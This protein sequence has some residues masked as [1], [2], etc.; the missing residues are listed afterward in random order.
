MRLG[1]GVR[2]L[3]FFQLTCLGWALFRAPSLEACAQVWRKLLLFEGL[4]LWAW[5]GHLAARNEVGPVALWAAVFVSAWLIQNLVP[6]SS[7]ELVARLWRWPS[8]PRAL[9]LAS[10]LY[11]AMLLAPL[12]PPEFIYFQF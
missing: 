9:V 5:L 12:D 1:R 8:V 7:K 6:E 2:A 11:A 10:L 3:L 4:D